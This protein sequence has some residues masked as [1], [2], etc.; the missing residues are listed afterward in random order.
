MNFLIGLRE[1]K[2]HLLKKENIFFSIFVII[3][4]FLDRLSKSYVIDNFKEVSY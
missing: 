2:N 4:F 1:F 3:I